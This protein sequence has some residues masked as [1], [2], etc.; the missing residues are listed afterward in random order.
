MIVPMTLAPVAWGVSRRY[1]LI[2]AR[3]SSHVSMTGTVSSSS[4]VSLIWE[5][6]L[7]ASTSAISALLDLPVEED[8]VLAPAAAAPAVFVDELEVEVLGLDLF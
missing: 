4:P 5:T 1:L 8:E 6:S 2:L 3:T 7:A